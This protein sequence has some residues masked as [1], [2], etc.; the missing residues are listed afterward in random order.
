MRK[1]RF[2]KGFCA[3]LAAAVLAGAT[4]RADPRVA[5]LRSDDI[6]AYN[7]AHS[8]FRQG[9]K[10]AVQVFDLGHGHADA[11]DSLR[12]SHPALVL[13]IGARAAR[14]AAEA[15]SDTPVVYCM[16]LDPA[17]NGIAGA[18]ITGVTL[19]IPVRSQIEEFRRVFPALSRLGVV[20]N[21]AKT[22]ALVQ[23]ARAAAAGL[24]ITVIAEAVPRSDQVPDAMSRLA[25]KVDALWLPPDATVV[26]LETFKL[27][28]ELSLTRKL[29]MMVFSSQFVK[30][31]ALL[32]LSPDYAASG[33]EAARI[34]RLILLGRKPSEI[35]SSP[36]KGT[37]VINT[38]T[39]KSLGLE[40]PASVLREAQRVE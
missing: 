14:A 23:E 17:A 32:A 7:E 36:T 11:L 8:G 31:G 15:L 24:G 28:L 1:S 30:A 40:V 4:A 25:G 34:V 35:P 20:Y 29:P 22:G 21:P 3:L 39:A 5:V 9:M 6:A 37:L 33:R 13:A 27:A 18:N 2:S 10:E 38:A 16:V 26:T 19:A 12:Q